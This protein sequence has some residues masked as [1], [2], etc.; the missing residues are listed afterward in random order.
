MVR[1]PGMVILSGF[2]SLSVV[3][4]SDYFRDRQN[5]T[6]SKRV[7]NQAWDEVLC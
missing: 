4:V 1:N 6:R 5:N 3:I 2:Y 7:K